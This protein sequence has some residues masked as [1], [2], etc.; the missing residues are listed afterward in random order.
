MAERVDVRAVP[1]RAVPARTDDWPAQTT[2]TIVRL[3]DS[4]AEKTHKVT[5]VA[6]AVVYGLIAAVVG[7]TALVLLL[8]AS[9][10]FL[11]VYLPDALFGEDHMWAVYLI[12]GALC[13]VSGL[14]LLNLAGRPQPEQAQ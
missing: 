9:F 2:D 7:F 3:V 13:A 1:P 11:D 14:V 5:T 12:V 6:R 10:R 8:I 4:V